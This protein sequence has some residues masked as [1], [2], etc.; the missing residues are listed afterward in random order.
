MWCTATA[1]WVWSGQ[2][3]QCWQELPAGATTA[4]TMMTAGDKHPEHQLL[5]FTLH[6]EDEKWGRYKP[7]YSPDSPNS[8]VYLNRE[9][10]SSWRQAKW[11]HFPYPS[12]CHRGMCLFTRAPRIQAC[13]A[14]GDHPYLYF[15]PVI[16]PKILGDNSC[17]S[18]PLSLLCQ[19]VRALNSSKPK[20]LLCELMPCD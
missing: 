14:L 12:Y 1:R 19:L 4:G 7:L 11:R 15:Y 20:T 10:P 5:S 3:R 17:I 2:A 9:K 13:F 8:S 6:L 18:V 16:L